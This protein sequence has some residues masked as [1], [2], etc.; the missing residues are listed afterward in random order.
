MKILGSLEYSEL[1]RLKRDLDSGGLLT[2]H[3]V[4]SKINEVE[5]SNR[6]FCASC[7]RSLVPDKNEIYTL[8]FGENTI[9]KKASFCGMDCLHDFLTVLRQDKEDLLRKEMN[10]V[11]LG[12]D[13]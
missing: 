8:V 1:Q 4:N 11:E 5:T 7:T 6:S 12:K 2:Q 3:V 9:K 13:F 10:N